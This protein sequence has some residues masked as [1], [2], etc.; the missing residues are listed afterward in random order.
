MPGIDFKHPRYELNEPL[1]RGGMGAVWEAIDLETNDLV[2][3]KLLNEDSLADQ[4]LFEGEVRILSELRHENIVH[5][6]DAGALDGRLF[7]V[8]ERLRGRPLDEFCLLYTSQ[9]PRDRG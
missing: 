4:R 3:I 7:L 2:A 1:G 9:S 8:M 6:L 5:L